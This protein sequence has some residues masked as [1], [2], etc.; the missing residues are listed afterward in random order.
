MEGDEESSSRFHFAPSPWF[1][2]LKRFGWYLRVQRTYV[3]GEYAVDT[4]RAVHFQRA[5]QEVLF[6]QLHHKIIQPAPKSV[7][8]GNQLH[9][10][11]LAVLLHGD[12]EV[13][14]QVRD[15]VLP[16][17][18]GLGASNTAPDLHDLGPATDRNVEV[19]L[20]EAK[21]QRSRFEVLQLKSSSALGTKLAAEHHGLH[22]QAGGAGLRDSPA[23]A[24]E[25]L[26]RL[27]NPVPDTC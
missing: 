17:E 6:V 12:G 11:I 15:G 19:V 1:V 4:V 2:Y 24:R 9:F 8:S 18:I 20:V 7:R 14:L 25:L 5:Q 27:L 3:D 26:L 16:A 10:K 22:Q 13:L 23:A 21:A